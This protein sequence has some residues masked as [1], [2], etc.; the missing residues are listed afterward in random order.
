MVVAHK[1]QQLV[2]RLI[3]VH[4]WHVGAVVVACGRVRC[5]WHVMGLAPGDESLSLMG[6]VTPVMPA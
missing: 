3:V 1:G 5:G 2:V 4:W 6:H